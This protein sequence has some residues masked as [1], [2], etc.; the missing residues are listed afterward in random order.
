MVPLLICHFCSLNLYVYRYANKCR[1]SQVVWL[2]AVRKNV[3]TLSPYGKMSDF[4]SLN[5]RNEHGAR[6]HPNGVT[7]RCASISAPFY[8]LPCTLETARRSASFRPPCSVLLYATAYT[9]NT[10][11]GE[12]EV[13][14]YIKIFLKEIS[15]CRST[16]LIRVQKIPIGSKNHNAHFVFE[17]Q[18]RE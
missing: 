4:N 15:S 13:R 16:C 12:F 10:A 1:L 6:C 5:A 2:F 9:A 7:R 17:S 18:N 14:N 8:E 3:Q 11:A